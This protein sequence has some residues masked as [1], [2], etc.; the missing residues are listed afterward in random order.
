MS[1]GH[2]PQ[3]SSAL[4]ADDL[5]TFSLSHLR[6]AADVAASAAVGVAVVALRIPGSSGQS[7]SILFGGGDSIFCALDMF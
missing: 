7:F 6:D 1:P 3:P 2:T 4:L 5:P